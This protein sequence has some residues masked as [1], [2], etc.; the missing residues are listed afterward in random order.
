M[1]ITSDLRTVLVHFDAGAD[2][3][4]RNGM[5]T[6]RG[7]SV[8]DGTLARMR[9]YLEWSAEG[10]RT[11]HLLVP[12]DLT[13]PEYEFF[14]SSSSGKVIRYHDEGDVVLPPPRR[15]GKPSARGS[16]THRA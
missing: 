1:I 11:T 5:R 15:R 14:T 12:S 6:A 7:K 8:S 9:W 3:A 2:L 13:A 10:G 16:E 4:R